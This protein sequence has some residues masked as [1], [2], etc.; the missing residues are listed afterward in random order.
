MKTL[1]VIAAMFFVLAFLLTL[2][3]TQDVLISAMATFAVVPMY[4]MGLLLRWFLRGLVK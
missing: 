4:L 2:A 1:N 3:C